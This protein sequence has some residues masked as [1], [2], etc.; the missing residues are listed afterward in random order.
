MKLCHPTSV[1]VL[2]LAT[3]ACGGAQ[4]NETSHRTSSDEAPARAE[5]APARHPALAP[6]RP[7]GADPVLAAL[8]RAPAEPGAYARAAAFF[9]DTDVA[10]MTLL[11]GLSHVAMGGD[12]VAVAE[13]MARVLRERITVV[14]TSS[15]RQVSTRLAP[16]T[17]PAFADASGSLEAPL[18]HLFEVQVT[19]ALAGFGGTWTLD[20]VTE[21]VSAY[22]A[23][24][25][26][27]NTLLDAR[28][29]LHQWLLALEGA[30]HL[31]SFVALAF[32][33]AFPDQAS[34]ATDGA[35]AWIAANPLRP[36]QAL[37]P[38]ALMPLPQQLSG[39]R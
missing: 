23:M 3:A 4:R 6:L 36:R 33:P 26:S 24:L 2:L 31:P 38:D 17:M 1:L 15:G 19:I 32:G 29:E 11:Y 30:G 10:G 37:M 20:G 21:A 34:L 13:P 12:P 7:A 18:A 35:R 5:P 22:V 14:P 27:P 9:A 28:L 39:R 16:G 25:R 8:E